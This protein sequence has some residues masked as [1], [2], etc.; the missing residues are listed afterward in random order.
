MSFNEI[1]E[2]ITLN[3]EVD[4]WNFMFQLGIPYLHAGDEAW[5]RFC[6]LQY[7]VDYS[8]TPSIERGQH[9]QLRLKLNDNV[10]GFAQACKAAKRRLS[11][12]HKQLP[13]VFDGVAEIQMELRTSHKYDYLLLP[14]K[15]FSE[16]C[17]EELHKLGALPPCDVYTFVTTPCYEI[18]SLH[19]VLVDWSPTTSMPN[20]KDGLL[21]CACA[22]EDA[23]RILTIAESLGITYTIKPGAY[24]GIAEP[25]PEWIESKR[26]KYGTA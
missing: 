17:W 15:R 5:L 24:A 23:N 4:Y 25:F 14:Y 16:L 7:G 9:G 13:Q 12:Q 11:Q 26:A 2:R 6:G 10:L 3:A 21:L 1:N 19:H 20:G 18:L 8:I 22:S